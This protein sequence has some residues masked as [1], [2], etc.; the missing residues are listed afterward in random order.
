MSYRIPYNPTYKQPT[1]SLT[2]VKPGEIPEELKALDGQALCATTP[3][4]N[5]VETTGSAK[6]VPGEGI[7]HTDFSLHSDGA[8]SKFT[9][10]PGKAPTQKVVD[11]AGRVFC[12]ARNVE[13]ADLIVNS[14][15]FLHTASVKIMME[16]QEA[17]RKAQ[18]AKSGLGQIID[19][20]AGG[21]IIVPPGSNN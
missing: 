20:N 21:N 19:P 18:E 17:A 13:V 8:L 7:E 9:D 5:K 14:L 15:N 4:E 1:P 6:P 10:N 11:G 12:I 2:P 16:Q 3:G